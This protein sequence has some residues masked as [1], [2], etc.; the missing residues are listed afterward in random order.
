MGVREDPD[1]W[2]SARA[3]LADEPTTSRFAGGLIVSGSFFE[4][5]AGGFCE[6]WAP[7]SGLIVSKLSG[8]AVAI[9]VQIP[10]PSLS[11]LWKMGVRDRGGS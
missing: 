1:P 3:L 5:L 2:G 9:R 8:L 6:G 11:M 4:F 10:V 7:G